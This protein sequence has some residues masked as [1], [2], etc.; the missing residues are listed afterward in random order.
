MQT[1]MRL[2]AVLLVLACVGCVYSRKGKPGTNIGAGS[3]DQGG[4][5]TQGESG[6]SPA[7]ID[8][9]R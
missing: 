8:R 6:G 7:L 9:E 1:V 5:W 3:G 2:I 4:P